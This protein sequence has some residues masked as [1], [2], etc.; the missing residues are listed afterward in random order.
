[1]INV[2]ANGDAEHLKATGGEDPR[3]PKSQERTMMAQ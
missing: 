2:P 3:E 1:L